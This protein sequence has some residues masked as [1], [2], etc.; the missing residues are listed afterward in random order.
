M[1]TVQ[2]GPVIAAI[3]LGTTSCRLLVARPEGTSF[4]VVDSFSRVVRLGE[5]IQAN[6]LLQ[7]AA[8][9][10]TLE[11]LRICR[12]KISK[13]HVTK[14]RAVTTEACRRAENSADLLQKARTELGINIEVITPLEEARLALS[15]CAAILDPTIPYA[16]AFDI[17]GGSTEIIWLRLL[18]SPKNRRSTIPI[19]EVI[20]CASLPF[21]V[22]TLSEIY[23]TRFTDFGIYDDLRQKVAGEVARFSEKNNIISHIQ[24]AEVQMAGTSGTVTTIGALHLKLPKYDRRFIDGLFLDLKDIHTVSAGL[25]AMTHLERAQSSCIGPGRA[26]LVLMGT[27]ILEGICDV[28]TLPRL[29]VADRG[30]REGIL[31]DL[32]EEL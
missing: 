22:V 11:A 16:V 32:L 18:P 24:N 28:W 10:R 3:D 8:I 30:V 27:A 20:D 25:L 4:R 31:M 5:G 2:P 21:G 15:G 9:T 12:D 29:R 14:I 7:P 6:N 26:D 23:G 13:N 1:P 17:G 19:V